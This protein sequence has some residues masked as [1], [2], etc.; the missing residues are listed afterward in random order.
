MNV[1]FDLCSI[2][3]FILILINCWLRKMNHG[4]VNQLFLAI[5]FVSLFCAVTD[6]WSALLLSVPPLS[7]MEMIVGSVLTYAYLLTRNV[8]LVLYTLFL[9]ATTRTD[10]RIR[11]L[12]RR[13]LLWL[14]EALLAVLLAQNLFTHNVFAVTA[15]GGY[16]RGPLMPAFYAVAAFY[17]LFGAVYCVCCKRYLGVRRWSAMLSLYVLSFGAVLI[18]LLYP[19][20]LVEMFSTA[21]SLL[22]ILLVVMRPEETMDVSVGLQSALAYQTDLRNMLLAKQRVQ[23]MAIQLVNAQEIQSFFGE[24]LFSPFVEEIAGELRKLCRSRHIRQD[25][26]FE[27]PGTIYVMLDDANRDMGDTV[28]AFLSETRERTRLFA[29]LGVQF[30][31]KVCLIRA[32]QDLREWKDIV[33]LGHR[34]ARMGAQEQVV[35]RASDFVSS[36]NFEVENHMEEILNR[37]LVEHAI[38]VYFQPIYDVKTGRFHSAEALARLRDSKYGMISPGIFIPAAETLG[39]ISPLGNEVMEQVFQ[40]VSRHDMDALGLA[41]IEVNLSVAQCMQRDLLDTIM[42]LQKKYEIDPR[43]INLE[44][45]ETTFDSVSEGARKNLN[46]LTQMGYTFSLDDY[47]TGYSNIQRLCKLPLKIIKIDKSMVDEI[48]NETGRRILSHTVQMMQS[49]DKEL[50][51]EGAETRETVDALKVM[52]CDYIQGFYYSRPLPPEKF[53]E[54][55]MAHQEPM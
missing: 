20:M 38:E 43:R 3:I 37:A 28:A 21:V 34:F 36:S 6:M 14:P 48:S 13:L 52:G 44:I 30:N 11:R 2:P 45:T 22:A 18:Q 53:V 24:A 49:I 50:V 9:F 7:R 55:L 39:L 1:A 17:G 27:R 54:F 8:T 5:S 33:N 16:R 23:I 15:L 19:Q 42:T 29:D 32:P 31:P 40:F 26:Y 35:F 12:R 51:V 4:R 41:Y 46:R 10:Y 25:L 47:G